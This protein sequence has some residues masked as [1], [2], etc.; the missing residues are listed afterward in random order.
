MARCCPRWTCR[1]ERASRAPSERK[2]QETH[3]LG[4]KFNSSPISG[5]AGLRGRLPILLAE[6]F[7]AAMGQLLNYSIMQQRGTGTHT[8]DRS[9]SSSFLYLPS[10]SPGVR[11]EVKRLEDAG[12]ARLIDAALAPFPLN[13]AKSSFSGAMMR[14]SSCACR[15]ALSSRI[16]M[17]R[18]A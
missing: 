1:K 4:G 12:R 13:G 10:K 17:S 9:S 6:A 5:I 2:R 14:S 11:L 7:D 16:L 15:L 18:R 8:A 3:V